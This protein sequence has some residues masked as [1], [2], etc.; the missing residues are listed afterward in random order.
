MADDKRPKPDAAPRPG[1]IPR[2]PSQADIDLVSS[3]QGMVS[4]EWTGDGPAPQPEGKPPAGAKP[5]RKPG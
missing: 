3:Q 4:D 2:P 1:Y 5:P